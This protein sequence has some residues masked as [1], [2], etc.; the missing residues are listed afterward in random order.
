MANPI[1]LYVHIPFCSKKCPYCA[2]YKDIH[3]EEKEIEFVKALCQELDAYKKES[4]SLKTLFFGGGTPTKLSLKNLSLIL[5]KIHTICDTTH[6]KEITLEANPESLAAEKLKQYKKLGINRISVG[7]QSYQESELKFLGRWH[8]REHINTALTALK[9][10]NWN[11]NVDLIFG[12]PKSSTES[13][14]NS[15]NHVLSFNPPHISTYALSIEENTPFEKKGIRPTSNENELQQ[16]DA[17]IQSLEQKGYTHYEVSAFSKKGHQCQHNLSYWTFTPYIGIGPSA[18]SFYKNTRYTHPAS[19][20]E[21]ISNPTP[22]LYQEQNESLSKKELIQEFLIA[23]LRKP[24]GFEHTSFT[25]LFN[26]SFIN[27]FK[28]EIS[29]LR[30]KNW[31]IST[32]SKTHVTKAGLRLLNDVL[33]HFI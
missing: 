13:L 31:L 28:K 20:K 8:T 21:Y 17:I 24:N 4:L 10:Q 1:S 33:L 27:M 7:I 26:E 6:L 30:Q 22:P 23:N 5:D 19:L 11:F 15:L 2:F 9:E 29:V 32:H 16:Y 18:S 14:Q 25:K 12:L 3:T